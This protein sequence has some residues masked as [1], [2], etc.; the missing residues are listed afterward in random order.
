MPPENLSFSSSPASRGKRGTEGVMGTNCGTI[1]SACAPS[2][3]PAQATAVTEQNGIFEG[4]FMMS[5]SN[6]HVLVVDD[7]PA[8]RRF[9]RASLTANGY[10]VSKPRPGEALSAV[11]TRR[12]DW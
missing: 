3:L 7:E 5:E 2:H 11:M 6:L 10:Q 8:I 4:N 12:P 9:L 1:S